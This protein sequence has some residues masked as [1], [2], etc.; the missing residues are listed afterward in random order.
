M[1]NQHVEEM[2]EEQLKE[3]KEEM[4]QFYKESM[5]YLEAQLSYEKTLT[6]IEEQRF[7]RASYQMQ[8]A[9]MMQG[10]GEGE[11]ELPSHEEL[12]EMAQANNGKTDSATKEPKKL[13][14]S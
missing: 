12:K 8:W 14:R 5:P 10:P 1:E 3:R 2:T 4:L 9:M 13:K 7:K 11:G 6:E